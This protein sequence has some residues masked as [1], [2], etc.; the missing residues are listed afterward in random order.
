MFNLHDWVLRG[1]KDAVRH[2]QSDYWV[3]LTATSYYEKGI[4]VQEDLA[5]IQALIDAKN[6]PAPEPE[7]VEEPEVIEEE[8]LANEEEE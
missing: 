1:L 5:E 8:P 6:A 3:I 7:P 2:G 4:L